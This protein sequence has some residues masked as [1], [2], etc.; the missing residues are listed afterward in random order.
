MAGTNTGV[1]EFDSM[2]RGLHIYNTVWTLVIAKMLR[3]M[4]KNTNNM[5]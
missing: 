3:I 5:L 2:V 1:Y 4:Q